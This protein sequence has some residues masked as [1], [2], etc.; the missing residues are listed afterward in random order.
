[1]GK[2]ENL[3]LSTPLN[4]EEQRIFFFFC[5]VEISFCSELNFSVQVENG[6]DYQ[7]GMTLNVAK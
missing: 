7:S 2:I 4:R 1:M 3:S 5:S 6:Q